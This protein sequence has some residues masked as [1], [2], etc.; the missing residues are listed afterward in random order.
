MGSGSVPF[1]PTLYLIYF[2]FK[3]CQH[4]QIAHP[5]RKFSGTLINIP[6]HLVDRNA[7]RALPNK[8]LPLDPL[9]FL[10]ALVSPH[11]SS[12]SLFKKPSL[13]PSSL[14][15]YR[16]ISNLPTAS[17]ML[18]RLTLFR[19]R[20]HITKSPNGYPF[21]SINTLGFSIGTALFWV[22]NTFPTF[23]KITTVP[24]SRHGLT[25]ANILNLLMSNRT[26]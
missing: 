13:D 11:F 7:T 15:N 25:V 9:N 8:T 6:A 24:R 17:N 22:S 26:T 4:S 10:L 16:S 21:Q 3:N 23:V 12:P 20:P 18:E 2:L 19:I 14:A 5:S 1:T